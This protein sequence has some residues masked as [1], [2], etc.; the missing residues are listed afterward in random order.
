MTNYVNI[1][2][3]QRRMFWVASAIIKPSCKNAAVHAIEELWLC[4]I[5]NKTEV[6]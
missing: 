4:I 2:Y 1:K 6:K 5:N 3:I